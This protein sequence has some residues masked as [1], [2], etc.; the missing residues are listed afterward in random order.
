MSIPPVLPPE[1]L[2]SCCSAGHISFG[3]GGSVPVRALESR[4]ELKR[5]VFWKKFKNRNPT[6]SECVHDTYTRLKRLKQSNN[7]YRLGARNRVVRAQIETCPLKTTLELLSVTTPKRRRVL[8]RYR[9]IWLSTVGFRFPREGSGGPSTHV[10]AKPFFRTFLFGVSFENKNTRNNLQ[11]KLLRLVEHYFLSL[12]HT[13]HVMA[14][15]ARQQ[16]RMSVWCYKKGLGDVFLL[17]FIRFYFT[18]SST[19]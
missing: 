15:I 1:E 7:S 5:L 10:H 11:F 14:R 13:Q 8:G 18:D 9:A 19:C 17:P 2:K 6:I 3:L 4:N 16:N 12:I